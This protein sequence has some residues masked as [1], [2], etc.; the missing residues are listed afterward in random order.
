MA[1]SVL[2]QVNRYMGIAVGKYDVVT[3]IILS[4]SCLS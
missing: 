3:S 2:P 4:L 1:S